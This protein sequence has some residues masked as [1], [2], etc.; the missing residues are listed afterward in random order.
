M[1]D[2]L[3]SRKHPFHGV[4][5]SCPFCEGPPVPFVR[6]TD[7]AGKVVRDAHIAESEDGL[8]AHAQV[9]CHECGAEGPVVDELAYTSAD[10]EALKQRAIDGWNNRDSRH[11]DL[12]DASVAAGLC[13]EQSVP[14]ETRS[15]AVTLPIEVVGL[16]NTAATHLRTWVLS[17]RRGSKDMAPYANTE[18]VAERLDYF[19][20]HGHLPQTDVHRHTKEG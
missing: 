13:T 5:R 16:L 15:S 20:A 1:A 9:F 8:H 2:S 11:R 18:E 10:V 3:L 4:L 6:F 17:H 7:D 12:F 19:I 14:S